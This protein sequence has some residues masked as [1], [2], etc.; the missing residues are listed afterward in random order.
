MTMKLTTAKLM[1]AAAFGAGLA[2]PAMAETITGPAAVLD[3]DIIRIGDY[4]I[5]LFGM[6]SV[7]EGQICVIEGSPWECWPAAGSFLACS[8]SP[9]SI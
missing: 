6:E 9:C 8:V 3:S 2:G 1:M 5:F 4:R 7:E